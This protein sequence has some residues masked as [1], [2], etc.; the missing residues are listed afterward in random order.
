MFYLDKLLPLFVYPLGLS[1]MLMLLA[2]VLRL[3]GRGKLGMGLAVLAACW[4]W[5]WSMPVASDRLRASL[6]FQAPLEYARDV[7]EGDV[8]VLLGGGISPA[9][10]D[11]PYPDLNRAGDRVWHAARLF[12]AGKAPVVIASGG[13]SPWREAE[14]T[15]AEA[16]RTL[17]VDL[18][19]PA[20]S[21]LLEDQSRNTREN[22]VL[23]A[24][25]LEAQ[26]LDRVLL[27]T[28]ALH[29]PRSL[30]TFRAAGIE[31]T[32]AATD[33]EVLPSPS[34]RDLRHWL[35]NA[36]AL[37]GSTRAMQEYLGIWVYWLRGW[38]K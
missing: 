21:I 2:L 23:T 3:L 14:Q 18:G 33:F 20:E 24:R 17:L 12:H 10:P 8:I 11:W 15:E 25:L 9:P 1:L 16:M 13:G 35:P 7:A 29:M 27:V 6:E 4:L 32:P 34:A 37:E 38:A 26:G 28:S 5:I 22:A 31:A 30:A 36:G 19:V